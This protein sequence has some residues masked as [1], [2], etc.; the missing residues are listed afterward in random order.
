MR[1]CA[2]CFKADEWKNKFN[3]QNLKNNDT[4]DFC[5]KKH[6]TADFNSCFKPY[7]LKLLAVFKNDRNGKPLSKILND[8]F[9]VFASGSTAK[10]VLK[11][12]NPDLRGVLNLN[13]NCCYKDEVLLARKRW[14]YVKSKIVNEFRFFT[15]IDLKEEGWD[16]FFGQGRFFSIKKEA[17][18]YRGRLNDDVK[19]PFTKASE[20]GMPPAEKARAGRVNPHGIPCLYLTEIP[21]TTIYEL[22]ATFG[23][24]ISI[25]KFKVLNDLNIIDFNY[26]PLLTNSIDNDSLEDDV[27]EFLLKQQIATDLSKPM[28]RYDN[29]EIEYV[30]TQY[31]CEFIKIL[32]AD[33]I[34]YNSAVHHN[35]RNLVLF[36]SDKVECI[37]V[38]VRTVGQPTM[39]FVG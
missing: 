15:S 39:G 27:S 3:L 22:R 35:G 30:P 26:R 9:D 7:L 24:K 25:G 12:L 13:A 5:G 21:E 36:K 20:L 33:G 28:R 10:A 8:D 17:E 19:K 6:A 34:R 31:I 38:D 29:K 18:F 14:E 32:G 2:E 11:A 16:D 37:S 23:D 1:I 4:C